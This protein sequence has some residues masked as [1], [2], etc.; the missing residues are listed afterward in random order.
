MVSVAVSAMGSTEL[1][2]VEPK[3]KINGTYCRDVLL[4][5]QLL[6][7]IKQL[8][9]DFFVFQRD[10]APFTEPE[11]PLLFS[12]EKRLTLFLQRSGHLTV[13]TSI[14]LITRSGVHCSSESTRHQ[15][16]ASSSY[17]NVFWRNGAGLIR[18]SLTVQ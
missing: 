9:G 5:R 1:F 3:A 10:S 6:P 2:F 8:S 14:Q 4:S 13:L 16:L 11:R 12:R 7:A 17:V 15:S 18:G